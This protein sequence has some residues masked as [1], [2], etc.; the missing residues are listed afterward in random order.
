MSANPANSNINQHYLSKVMDLAESMSVEVI[1][2]ILDVRGMKLV[3][4]GA[5][6]TRALREKL[7]VHKLKQPLESSLRV[8]DGV[9]PAVILNTATRLM[10]SSAPLARV[11][12]A[13]SGAGVSPLK[14]M[15]DMDF[16]SAMG[17]MLTIANRPGTQA[18]EHA[19]LVSMLS[20]CMAKKLRLTEQEQKVAG[21][22]G[23][24]HDIGELYIDPAFM[25]R[26]KRLQPHEW[27]HV[28]VH[29]RIGQMLINELESYPLAVGRAVAEHHERFDGTGYPRQI[30]GNHIS[31][32]GQAVSVAEMIAGLLLKD[33]PLERAELALKIIPGEHAHDLLSAI[34]GALRQPH[35]EAEPV[36]SVSNAAPS[37]S[38][39]RLFWRIS[40]TLETGRSLLE[41]SSAK[42]PVTRLLLENTMSRVK[43]IQR[44]FISTGLD[45]YLNQQPELGDSADG[46]LEFEKEV[47]S[48]EIQWRLRDIARDLALHTST[49]DEKSIFAA[50]I[51][52]L[53]D[54]KPASDVRLVPAPQPQRIVVP[55]G[56]VSVRRMAA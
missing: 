46:A 54:D 28:V 33:R 24:L 49:P 13:T 56:G 27:S 9:E 34:S 38:V 51:N 45:V 21:L 43:N 35:T 6:V 15:S 53:D 41:G 4:K 19:V 30:V 52:L 16:G 39:E 47:A 36:A 10:E 5:L 29:P 17:L 12:R 26:G 18:L 1:V 31:P 14:I 32:A 20:I 2:D 50:L 11:V 23:L 7:I 8:I 55:T 22:A 3:A 44:A 42:S 37:E 25:A 40:A 48:R